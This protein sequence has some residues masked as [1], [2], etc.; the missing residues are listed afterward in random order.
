MEPV[1]YYEGANTMIGEPFGTVMHLHQR[2]SSAYYGTD[3]RD[4]LSK[5][6]DSWLLEEVYQ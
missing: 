1:T 6:P 5:F 2:S 3:G 4:G